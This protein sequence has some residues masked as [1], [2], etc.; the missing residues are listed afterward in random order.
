MIVILINEIWTVQGMLMVGIVREE[1]IQQLQLVSQLAM[2]LSLLAQNSER[3]EISLM[4]M[5]ETQ[6]EWLSLN[7]SESMMQE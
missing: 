7:L 4:G 1:I 2:T 6:A 5:D 3:M